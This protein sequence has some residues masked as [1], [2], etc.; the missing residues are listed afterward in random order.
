M[1]KALHSFII[2]NKQTSFP[3]AWPAQGNRNHLT[4]FTSVS[5]AEHPQLT[6]SNPAV[7]HCKAAGE[8]SSLHQTLILLWEPCSAL[9]G[10]L[11]PQNTGSRDRAVPSLPTQPAHLSLTLSCSGAGMLQPH[12]WMW[13]RRVLAMRELHSHVPMKCSGSILFS[14]SAASKSMPWTA[15]KGSSEMAGQHSWAQRAAA[16]KAKTCL[17]QVTQTSANLHMLRMDLSKACIGAKPYG[18]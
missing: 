15:L 18:L 16:V 10:Q 2:I 12:Y 4:G 8:H 14:I 7:N 5:C 3:L 6:S 17:S 9:W 1:H 11:H 13:D